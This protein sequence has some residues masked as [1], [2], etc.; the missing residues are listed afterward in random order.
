MPKMSKND[1]LDER[2]KLWRAITSSYRVRSRR[3][4][5]GWVPNQVNFVWSKLQT[6]K[7]KY[8]LMACILAKAAF[9]FGFS[10]I[11]HVLPLQANYVKTKILFHEFFLHNHD[12]K[13]KFNNFLVGRFFIQILLV[14]HLQWCF[15]NEKS[16]KMD[17]VWGAISPSSTVRFQLYFL[18]WIPSRV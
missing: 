14:L 18:G 1:I 12:L 7:I 9:G 13:M 11:R 15:Y 10:N 16:E 6:Y 3:N 4:H 17:E 8:E 5:L 2:K